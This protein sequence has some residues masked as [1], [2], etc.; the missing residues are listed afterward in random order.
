MKLFVTIVI[1]LLAFTLA[2]NAQQPKGPDALAGLAQLLAQGDDPQFQ[3]DLL[4][5]MS[6][7]LKGRRGVRMPAGWEAAAEKLA[8]SPNSQ[9]RELAQSLSVTFGSASALAALRGTLLDA[10]A[11]AAARSNALVSLLQAKD[12]QLPGA[13]QQLLGDATLR[14]GALRGLAVYDDSKTPEAILGV[15]ASLA[16]S[17]K[18][19]ALSTLASRVPYAKALLTAVAEN[20]IPAKDLTADLVRQLRNLN[21]ATVNEQVTQTWGV[22]HETAAD[23]LKDIQRYK[24]LIAAKGYGNARRGRGVFSRTCQQCH[25][26]YGEGGKVAPD[27]T[28]SSRADLDYALQN[29]VDPNAII[30]N[31]YRTWNLETKD[32]R[33]I[34]GI[35]TRQDANS[36]TIVTANETIVIPRGDVQSLKQTELSLMPEGL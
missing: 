7:G 22:T 17:E 2:S 36:V 11:G 20:K 1:A 8:K 26:L 18:R 23:K 13:L 34:T 12:P 10:S 35:V 31:D 16:P 3:L 21:D 15:Y 25:T 9:V 19:D 32:D 28:G 24:K 29:I 6:D 30:P 5:G 27:L 4:K 14:G 33:S